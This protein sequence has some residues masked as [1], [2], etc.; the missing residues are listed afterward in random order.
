MELTTKKLRLVSPAEDELWTQPWEVYKK[1]GE[2]LEGRFCFYGDIKY[3]E[4][5]LQHDFPKENLENGIA[6]EALQ[7]FLSWA[8]SKRKDLYFLHTTVINEAEEKFFKQFGWVEDGDNPEGKQLL[9]WKALTPW[10]WIYGVTGFAVGIFW[11]QL[12]NRHWVFSIAGAV[13]GFAI[14]IFLEFTEQKKLSKA[15]EAR[16][17]YL[18]S[19]KD[20]GK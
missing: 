17:R 15:L 5:E 10:R 13:L 16:R 18:D 3:G 12:M 8:Y 4:T 7:G 2:E 19:I 20:N 1:N 6:K 9:K 14:G 11:E